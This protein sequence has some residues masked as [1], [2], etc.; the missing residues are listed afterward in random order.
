MELFKNDQGWAFPTF[1]RGGDVVHLR[2]PKEQGYQRDAEGK[3]VRF[4][5]N[6][7]GEWVPSAKGRPRKY[8]SLATPHCLRRTF[9]STADEEG[10]NVSE[11]VMKGLM[12]HTP[13]STNM[14]HRYNTP[15]IDAMRAATEKVS[16]FLIRKAG[17]AP[18]ATNPAGRIS[19]D[20]EADGR[21]TA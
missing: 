1:D 21:A 20:Q 18:A 11:R 6:A 8:T 17:V 3:I 19:G 14:T 2:E 10:V 4:T 7:E 15:S 13:D 9:S 12:N 5:R 16:A